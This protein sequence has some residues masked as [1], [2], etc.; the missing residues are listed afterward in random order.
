MLLC[1][2]GPVYFKFSL[3]LKLNSPSS[4]LFVEDDNKFQFFF[5]DI[6]INYKDRQLFFFK[7]N[8]PKVGSFLDSIGYELVK[9]VIEIEKITECFYCGFMRAKIEETITQTFDI[10]SIKRGH[11]N[12][13]SI[14][15]LDQ[16]SKINNTFYELPD[17]KITNIVK[18]GHKLN[19]VT[20]KNYTQDNDSLFPFLFA[21]I[22]EGVSVYK[23]D[24]VDNFT[25]I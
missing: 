21:N 15:G 2:I 3:V 10:K 13:L 9:R 25:R 19:Q 20:Q 11:T 7:I 23:V 14:Y 8:V 6:N 17:Q 12:Q 24:S 5:K 4:K 18:V 1:D 16:I 22:I